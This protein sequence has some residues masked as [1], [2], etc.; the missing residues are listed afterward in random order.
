MNDR[1]LTPL[2]EKDIAGDS[3]TDISSD[4]ST[5]AASDST[6]VFTLPDSS[7]KPQGEIIAE[8]KPE[9]VKV[10]KPK[11]PK[12]PEYDADP[13]S[14]ISR[15]AS[16]D[17]DEILKK[18]GI[19]IPEYEENEK[20]TIK[21]ELEDISSGPQ[22]KDSDMKVSHT[23][24]FKL[25]KKQEMGFSMGNTR[26]FHLDESLVTDDTEERLAQK[27]KNLIQ[28]F[29]VLSKTQDQDQ[30]ILEIIQRRKKCH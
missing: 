10:Y 5:Q 24:H 9:E 20:P 12:A 13:D 6:M 30:A 28:N 19:E 11:T 14:P 16:F 1:N 17:I 21:A 4:E 29:R 18:L 3:Y 8:E 25:P 27:R 15:A 2:P 7:E 23:R 22:E 26:R